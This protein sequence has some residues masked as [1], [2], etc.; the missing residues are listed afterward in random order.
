MAPIK[1]GDKI[2]D[3]T[4]TYINDEGLQTLSIHAAGAGKKIIIF[5]V[6][7]AFT[8]TCSLKHVPSFLENADALKAKGVSAIYCVSV[9][10]PFVMKQWAQTYP[11]SNDIIQFLADGSATFTKAL[12][13]DLDLSDK[14]LG[15]RSNRYALLVDDLT[16]KVANIEEGGGFEVSSAQGILKA[17]D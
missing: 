5:A 2:P 16:V 9:N 15:I 11:T 13:L 8:P 6:P 7:G 12:G 17:L 14:G 3:A 1:V 10:D 4:L